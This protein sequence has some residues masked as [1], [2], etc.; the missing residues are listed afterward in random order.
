MAGNI[1]ARDSASRRVDT[2]TDSR[3]GSSSTRTE[4]RSGNNAVST[5]QGSRVDQIADEEVQ[6]ASEE[7]ASRR[8]RQ[9]S[10]AA[11][12]QSRL[13]QIAAEEARRAAEER[14]RKARENE[15]KRRKD[16]ANRQAAAN[17]VDQLGEE[18]VAR[19]AGLR[20]SA[21]DAALTEQ[22]RRKQRTD[23]MVDDIMP[24]AYG[25]VNANA[26]AANIAES[27]SE[28][29]IERRGRRNELIED[30]VMSQVYDKVNDD[31]RTAREHAARS[32][33][34]N[35]RLEDSKIG[36]AIRNRERLASE[37]EKVAEKSAMRNVDIED[38]IMSEA[39]DALEA[40]GANQREIDD[41]LDR[42]ARREVNADS[43]RR[44]VARIREQGL[45]I[46]EREPTTRETLDEALPE[47]ASRNGLASR[48]P[49]VPTKSTSD[50]YRGYVQ[51]TN[52]MLEEQAQAQG[53]NTE[54]RDYVRQITGNEP[55]PFDEDV[56]WN[57]GY[58]V[59]GLKRKKWE[60]IVERGES[61]RT[62]GAYK[63]VRQKP[64]DIS[65][66]ASEDE[67]K[68]LRKMS[69]I[70]NAMRRR[71][72]NPSL[73]HIQG[74]RLETHT[75]TVNGR[76]RTF[77]K[78][79]YDERITYAIN[80]VQD[81][82]DCSIS[83]VMKLIQLRAGL[84]ISVDGTIAGVNPNKFRL[85]QDQAYELLHDIIE[86]Q[87]KNGHPLGPVQ[88]IPVANGVRDDTGKFV[89]VAGTRCFPLGYMPN[90]LKR[91]LSRNWGSALHGLSERQI[92]ERISDQWI[93]D[94]YPQL[95]AN[96][97]GNLMYQ[98]RAIESMM[99]SLMSIDGI[100]PSG[101]GIPEVTRNR[102]LIQMRTERQ[103]TEDDAIA[104]SNQVKHEREQSALNQWM[105]RRQKAGVERDENGNIRPS[106]IRRIDYGFR[107]LSSLERSAKAANIMIMI[108]AV[109]EEAIAKGEQSFANMLS[110]IAFNSMHGDIAADYAETDVIRTASESREA[111]EAIEVA[112]SLYNIGGHVAVDAFFEEMQ[113]GRYMN[114][115]TRKDL[116]D[117]LLR[118]GVTETGVS[119][120]L[121]QRLG[122]KTDGDV[123][124]FLS[125]VSSVLDGLMLG[126]ALFRDG[127]ARRF[128]KMALA[129]MARASIHGRESYTN[130]E[131]GEWASHG[132][133]E[134]M[135]RSLLMT[136]AGREAFMTQGVTSLGRKSPVE[137]LV[138]SI[139]H[140]N[141]M[142]EFAVRTMFDRFPEYGVNKVLQMMPMSNTICYLTSCGISSMG[143]MLSMVAGEA[144]QTAVTNV[145]ARL[146]NAMSSVRDYQIGGRMSFAEGLRKNLMYDT[147]MGAEK[148]LIGGLY[149]AVIAFFGG[150]QPPDDDRDKYTWSEWKIGS[151]DD[152]VPIKWAWWMDDISGIGFPLGT[153]WAICE[154]G[155][156]SNEAKATATNVFINAIS[157]M[158]SGSVIFDAIDL[159]NDFR[160]E[161]MFALDDTGSYEPS[162]D[163][164]LM[165]SIEQGFWNLVGDLTPT[166]AGQLVPWSKD[167]ILRTGMDDAHT[168]GRVYDTSKMSLDEAEDEYK[169]KQT[170][171]YSDY[172]RRRAT[173]TNIL[174]AIFMD[175]VT[176][177]GKSDSEI[178]GYKYTEQPLD[179]MTDPY[180]EDKFEQFF[181]DLDP[182]TSTIPINDQ[183]ERQEAL[184]QHAKEVVHWIDTHYQNATQAALD[185]FVLN[186]DARINCINYCHGMINKAWEKYYEDLSNGW[187]DDD[188]YQQVL[189]DRKDAIDHYNNLIY[190]FFQSD[191][192]GWTVPRYVRQESDMET[193][194]VDEQ[195][196]PM[197][198]VDTLGPV[199][200]N[201]TRNVANA[202]GTI[203][204]A[205]NFLSGEGI[206]N[207]GEDAKSERYWY[208]NTNDVLPFISPISEDKGRNY[209]TIP[210]NIVLDEDGNPVNDVESMYDNAANMDAI[211]KGRLSGKDVLELM[212][213][214]QGNNLKDDINEELAIPR[215]GVPTLGGSGWS[216]GGRPWR[217][218][219]SSVPEASG[220]GSLTAEQ[221]S[222]RLGVKSNLPTDGKYAA[223]VNNEKGDSSSSNNYSGWKHYNSYGGGGGGY[224]SYTGGGGS[225]S[226][227]PK[228]YS[229][230]KQVY[231]QR[232]SG[233][234]SPRPYKATSTYLRPAFYTKGSR[235]AYR[236]QDI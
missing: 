188:E 173:Q 219:E 78:R 14:A 181:L 16:E 22:A 69:S 115:L 147:V 109:P 92:E 143:D 208:G 28:R 215:G 59:T 47:V 210:Y 3:T 152:A 49:T 124:G 155:G 113:D 90:D 128:T 153:A 51:S 87:A 151:G 184:D 76:R 38:S 86:S 63:A 227:N 216:G 104:Q 134:E 146:G 72:V 118:W 161:A 122:L 176:E 70:Q 13:D 66:D 93:N 232:A 32:K 36:D 137:H 202:L 64:G 223:Q 230:A 68:F 228:I 31:A 180:A 114:R 100:D 91:S 58:D 229:H 17:R 231:S 8:A 162:R 190:N 61:S 99:R 106:W 140:A 186:Y 236:R 67:G 18:E 169:T 43:L 233:M 117:F 156:W 222:E 94:T 189:Q 97:G 103:A 209:E 159:V 19:A 157:N 98:A 75:E 96:T 62:K 112:N 4:R 163:E 60:K 160:N 116:K 108:S 25:N 135:I 101:L 148:I 221:M 37:Q 125:T 21:R 182:A 41:F 1:N 7:R 144:D 224:Y 145:A 50:F 74:E 11:D 9:S 234:S 179:T 175:W 133:G 201:V 170:G 89:I 142:T 154:Q 138:R 158:N 191:E 178:T 121:R 203:P 82:Y 52:Q 164:W 53:I 171:S 194:Y 198:Y 24:Q 56:L 57:Q 120:Q 206:E 12:N 110:D 95:C 126:S 65:F 111:I 136:G 183:A 102:M 199:A 168:A 29:E 195:G 172:M 177:A 48:V 214:G 213:G 23:S 212:W 218:L 2:R 34:R 220:I 193:R 187:L 39:Y 77:A 30:D 139:M 204:I 225:Y 85:T 42:L 71:Y 35:R 46:S 45:G 149:A 80:A 130:T 167:F 40:A 84:G 207:I 27:E 105:A 211:Q 81:L 200:R 127:E 54:N 83:D 235:E 26:R 185:G 141:G 10:T 20:S 129:E 166:V 226:Y 107:T 5:Q 174:Y 150:I 44:L 119:D 217:L 192:I 197:T 6:R 88:G 79:V 165:T 15:E 33:R 196:N 123:R 132:G 55:A 131:V 205:G 73:V